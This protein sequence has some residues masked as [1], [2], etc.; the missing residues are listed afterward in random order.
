MKS[1]TYS[2]IGFIII[3]L[4]ILSGCGGDS[5]S[6]VNGNVSSKGDNMEVNL[7]MPKALALVTDAVTAVL[8]PGGYSTTLVISGSTVSGTI[9]SVPPGIYTLTITY[10]DTPTSTNL[11]TVTISGISVSVGNSTPVDILGSDFFT[12]IDDDLDGFSNLAEV[13]IGTDPNSNSGTDVPGGGSPAFLAGNN[14]F[15]NSS[16][17]SHSF[18]IVA[19]EAVIGNYSTITNNSTDY[20]INAGFKGY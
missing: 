20:V 12:D 17:V 11:A 6:S 9:S 15:S 2:L 5:S 7:A 10:R 3:F 8:S 1:K 13:R 16:T 14:V 19:G 4:F 18:T